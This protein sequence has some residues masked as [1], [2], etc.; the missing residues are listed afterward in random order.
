MHNL[1][2]G[3]LYPPSGCLDPGTSHRLEFTPLPPEVRLGGLV[4]C[5]MTKTVSEDL[6]TVLPKMYSPIL[7]CLDFLLALVHR[8]NYQYLIALS[9]D[10]NTKLY[11]YVHKTTRG[12]EQ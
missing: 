12:F 5:F 11:F 6:C 9:V 3:A 4:Q 7:L 8:C 10:R 1:P 2:R